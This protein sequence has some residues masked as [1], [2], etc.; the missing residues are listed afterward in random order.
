MKVIKKVLLW[1][2]NIATLAIL[3]LVLFIV[4]AHVVEG[5][6][7]EIELT[8]TEIQLSVAMGLLFLGALVGLKWRLIGG[9][10]SILSF[11]AFAII[12]GKILLGFVFYVF[13]VIGISNLI[14]HFLNRKT[15]LDE[16]D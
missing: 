14:L 13:L 2:T 4:G 3:G 11:V 6:P 7:G 15:S 10:V 16:S 9:L 8:T 1:T 5:F 12:Q